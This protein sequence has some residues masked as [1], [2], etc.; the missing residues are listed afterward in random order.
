M[1]DVVR[2]VNDFAIFQVDLKG[3]ATTWN[4]SVE[5][6]LGW[7]R[8]DFIGL[9]AEML[10]PPEDVAKGVHRNELRAAA[11]EGSS[12]SDLW[13]LQKDGTPFYASCLISRSIDVSGHVIG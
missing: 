12:A 7:P 4:E 9:P 5:R 11:E 13:L 10:F 1:Q 6:L 2:F 8:E 3:F